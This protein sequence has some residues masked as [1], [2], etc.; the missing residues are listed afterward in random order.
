MVS[1]KNTD[2]TVQFVLLLQ[3][4]V[5]VKDYAIFS[6]WV[7][8]ADSAPGENKMTVVEKWLQSTAVKM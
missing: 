3:K 1:H 5:T 6:S 2:T 4:N 7:G 8:R